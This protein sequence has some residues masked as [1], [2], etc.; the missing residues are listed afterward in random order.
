MTIIIRLDAHHIIKLLETIFFKP[1][2]IL[3]KK[4]NY[5]KITDLVFV[6]FI[7]NSTSR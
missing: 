6:Q 4:R 5:V 2:K 1:Y 7:T 3:T